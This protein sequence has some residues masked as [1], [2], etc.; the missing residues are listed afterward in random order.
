MGKGILGRGIESG[1]V[2]V[3]NYI[4]YGKRI[5]DMDNPREVRRM[6][7]FVA[8]SILHNTKMNQLIDF[9]RQDQVLSNFLQEKPFPIE[10]VTRCFFYRGATFEERW[11]LIYNHYKYLHCKIKDEYFQQI[12]GYLTIEPYYLWKMPLEDHIISAELSVQAGQRKEGCLSVLLKYD[13]CDLYQ[14][15]FWISPDKHGNDSLWIGAM[16]GP[17]MDGAKD[18]IKKIT[19]VCHGYRTKNLVLYIVR[20]I[21]KIMGIKAIYA[22]TNEGYYANNH[23][24]VDR[25][26]KTSFSDFWA[27]VGGCST[28][29]IRFYQ[30]PVEENR[31]D[32]EDIPTRK[33]AIYRRRFNFLDELD[34]SIKN[35]MGLVLK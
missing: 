7:V 4:D 8:R 13:N 26:L 21:A 11:N 27:E 29:D 28:D 30:L 9:F 14:I 2:T 5:Y 10:Q 16:Q 19:K 31:K 33:R 18:L 25:K 17:N 34:E 6:A 3:A 24:R 35:S 32:V 22:V 23:V 1:D 12:N 20:A 15:M